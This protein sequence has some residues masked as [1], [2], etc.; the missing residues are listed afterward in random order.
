MGNKSKLVKKTETKKK[1]EII[2]FSAYGS[3][4]KHN[5]KYVFCDRRGNLYDLVQSRET[6]DL[7]SLDVVVTCNIKKN[8]D[9]GW[10]LATVDKVMGKA[11]DPSAEEK[12]MA[13]VYQLDNP[14][15]PEEK[16]QLDSLPTH[17]RPEDMKN[18]RDLRHIPFITI[19][20]DKAGDFDDAV[21]AEKLSDGT[22][23]LMVA[24]ADVTH[25]VPKGSPLAKRAERVG[26]TSYLHD[27]IYHMYDEKLAHGICS[28]VEGEDR[29]TVCTSIHLDAN[30]QVLDY[31]IEPAVINSRHRLTYK[32]ADYIEL[33]KLPDVGKLDTRGLLARTVD[34]KESLHNLFEVSDIIESEKK[35]RGVLTIKNNSPVFILNDDG[36]CVADIDRDHAEIATKVIE[37]TAVLTNE[38]WADAAH[39]IGMPFVYRNH[40]EYDANSIHTLNQR[41]GYFGLHVPD[42]PSS[43]DLQRVLNTVAGKK[44]YEPVVMAI[45]RAFGKA[46]YASENKGHLALGIKANI[47]SKKSMM[48]FDPVAALDDARREYLKDSGS[49]Y[50]LKFVGGFYHTNGYGHTTSGIR[51]DSDCINL[52][53]MNSMICNG[54]P[55]YTKQE[56]DCL[57]DNLNYAE[58]NTAMAEADDND[59]LAT[60]RWA[61]YH[62]GEAFN[63]TVVD[64]CNGIASVKTEHGI[65]FSVP[66]NELNGKVFMGSNNHNVKREEGDNRPRIRLG[67][68]IRVAIKSIQINPYRIIGSQKILNKHTEHV[69]NMSDD[70]STPDGV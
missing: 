63:C 65:H 56:I 31:T 61:V 58:R 44:C 4:I 17:V 70:C 3:I 12:A 34:I 64:F 49:I 33:G 35:R 11:F 22:Y 60:T 42:R 69:E 15:T 36:T 55:L 16:R 57:C 27:V 19:D 43:K 14:L 62:M 24:I 1:Y 25:Y 38:L 66:F 53:Q 2:E 7:C 40:G 48:G 13:S 9:T 41:L 47:D 20:P 50:G 59:M 18:R 21:Y 5:G 67:D 28:L 39:R 10:A 45:L 37:S 6:A 32:Q 68:N 26:N 51:R 23:R 52:G 29:L 8:L 46:E 54:K 30:G